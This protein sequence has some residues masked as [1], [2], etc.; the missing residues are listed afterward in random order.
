MDSQ[1]EKQLI[2]SNGE[3]WVVEEGVAAVHGG[4]SPSD[5]KLGSKIST[6]KLNKKKINFFPSQTSNY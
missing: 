5:G 1:N 4:R 3:A 6:S 2:P